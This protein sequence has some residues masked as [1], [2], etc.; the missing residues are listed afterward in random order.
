MEIGL[1]TA[2]VAARTGISLRRLG[3]WDR[4]GIVSPSISP[5]LGSGSRRIYSETDLVFV[6]L[7]N[8]IRQFGGTLDLAMDV[9]SAVRAAVHQHER[10]IGLRVLTSADA[11]LHCGPDEGAIQRIIDNSPALMVLNFEPFVRDARAICTHPSQPITRVSDV[12]G[13]V[14]QFVIVPT[15]DSKQAVSYQATCKAYPDMVGTGESVERAID[16]LKVVIEA[17]SASDAEE[18]VNIESHLPQSSSGASAWGGEW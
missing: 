3:H 12:D 10:L 9:A 15:V 1:D 18:A 16:A 14:L 17:A 8:A 4:L 2:T 7:V 6:L 13:L 11:V 5:S